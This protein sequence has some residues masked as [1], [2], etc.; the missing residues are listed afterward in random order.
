MV[1]TKAG[2]GLVGCDPRIHSGEPIILGT[3]VSIRSIILALRDDYPGD[4]AAAAAAFRV[5]LAAVEAALEYYDGH[6]V[7]IERDIEQRERAAYE[8]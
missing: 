4:T 7:E 5:S 1:T 2:R 8:H 6:K 3:R